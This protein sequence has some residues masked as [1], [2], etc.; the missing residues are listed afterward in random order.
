MAFDQSKYGYLIRKSGF[1]MPTVFSITAAGSIQRQRIEKIIE[2]HGGTVDESYHEIIYS[3]VDNA[4][5]SL[6]FSQAMKE[7]LVR[8]I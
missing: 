1:K 2:Q 4:T 7:K 8:L 6:I 5:N 3:G